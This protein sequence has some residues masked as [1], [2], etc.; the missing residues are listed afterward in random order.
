MGRSRTVVSSGSLS[1]LITN[2]TLSGRYSWTHR[3]TKV[4]YGQ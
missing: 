2:F 1:L 4:G 3:V